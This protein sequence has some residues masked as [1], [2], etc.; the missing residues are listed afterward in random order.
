M[1]AVLAPLPTEES[2]LRVSVTRRVMTDMLPRTPGRF[3]RR[4]QM[5]RISSFYGMVIGMFYREHG[6]PHFHVRSAEFRA[7][8]AIETLEVLEGKLPARALRLIREWV[9]LHREELL[10]NWQKART[11]QPLKEIPP[12][13]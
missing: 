9:E 11:K 5:P 10:A 3:E 1:G 13:P 8:I 4:S 12:L 6:V 2:R 7:S